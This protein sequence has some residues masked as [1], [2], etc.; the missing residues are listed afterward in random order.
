MMV[1]SIGRWW[2]SIGTKGWQNYVSL[3]GVLGLLHIVVGH[4]Q[5]L[6]MFNGGKPHWPRFYDG[7]RIFYRP[8]NLKRWTSH[9]VGIQLWPVALG[10]YWHTTCYGCVAEYGLDLE[11]YR[12]RSRVVPCSRCPKSYTYTCCKLRFCDRCWGEHLFTVTHIYR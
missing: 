1:W 9:V 4:F 2:G 7:P 3:G 8:S 5:F 10:I 11:A 12:E 6:F